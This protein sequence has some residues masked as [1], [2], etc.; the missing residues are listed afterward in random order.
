MTLRELEALHSNGPI[1]Q[2][3]EK[4][5][6]KAIESIAYVSQSLENFRENQWE[7]ISH[8][9]KFPTFLGAE[10][11]GTQVGMTYPLSRPFWVIIH[12][13]HFDI[14]TPQVVKLVQK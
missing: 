4:K 1:S 9:T 6:S 2:M 12:H 14:P 7:K 13:L 3:I 5:L 8:F 10:Q 11:V